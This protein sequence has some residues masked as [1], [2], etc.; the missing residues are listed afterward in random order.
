MIPSYSEALLITPDLP[1]DMNNFQCKGTPRSVTFSSLSALSKTEKTNAN[2][3][4][5]SPFIKRCKSYS[6]VNKGLVLQNCM[7]MDSNYATFSPITSR[8]KPRRM[9]TLFRRDDSTPSN[10]SSPQSPKDFL[11]R[12]NPATSIARMSRR[13]SVTN[14]YRSTTSIPEVSRPITLPEPPPYK[15]PLS[16]TRPLPKVKYPVAEND[17]SPQSEVRPY[18][19]IM[20]TSL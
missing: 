5:T 14:Y 19:T 7:H 6:I 20:E 16:M 10:V 3:S 2:P 13:G 18:W 12:I 11:V 9:F 8:N 1:F 15:K 17:R 4:D